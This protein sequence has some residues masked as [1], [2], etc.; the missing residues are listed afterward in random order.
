MSSTQTCGPTIL[1]DKALEITA[2]CGQGERGCMRRNYGAMG[3]VHDT[4]MSSV[5]P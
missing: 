5:L 4:G 1:V 2:L 3:I